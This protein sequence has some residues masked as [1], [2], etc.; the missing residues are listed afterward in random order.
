MKQH[1][2]PTAADVTC[3]FGTE[4]PKEEDKYAAL[5]SEVRNEVWSLNLPDFK[6]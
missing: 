6:I 5:V 4:C 1:V 2:F 3:H